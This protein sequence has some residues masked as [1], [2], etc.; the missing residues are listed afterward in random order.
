ML[1][2]AVILIASVDPTLTQD[3][4]Q[5]AVRATFPRQQS[6]T[7]NQN[8]ITGETVVIRTD[9]VTGKVIGISVIKTGVTNNE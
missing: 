7:F 1:L 6:V 5:G 2:T 4:K 8:S 9:E 3:L